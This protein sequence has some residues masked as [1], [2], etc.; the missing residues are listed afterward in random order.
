MTVY[1]LERFEEQLAVLCDDDGR[2]VAVDKTVLPADARA[3][4]IFSYCDGGYRYEEAETAA[5][6]T[7]IQRLE[8]LLKN[9]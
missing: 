1:S 9:R 6:R 2:T 7:R 4:D 8:Q 5:R 3:G